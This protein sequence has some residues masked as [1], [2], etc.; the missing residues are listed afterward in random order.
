M[1][2]KG[3]RC[4]CPIDILIK[5]SGSLIKDERFYDWLSIFSPFTSLFILCGGGDSITEILKREGI[6]YEFGPLG[7]EI[8]SVKG[9]DLAKQV[10]EE[11]KTFVEKK[12]QQRGI[13][14][15]VFVPVIKIGDRSCHINGDNYA[16]S[17][18]P[19]FDKIYIVTLKGRKKY[20]SRR[21]VKIEV[22]Y[23]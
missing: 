20:F 10:L 21:L 8:E 2:E 22:V 15:V 12:L 18:Y 16:I 17:L 3:E 23:L 7:R 6:P 5:V 11:E 13:D 19:N 4:K 1:A 14:A 9:R